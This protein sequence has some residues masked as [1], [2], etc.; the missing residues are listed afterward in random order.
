[1]QGLQSWLVMERR[2]DMYP[3]YGGLAQPLLL[4]WKELLQTSSPPAAS[5]YLFS[6]FALVS[7]YGARIPYLNEYNDR[8]RVDSHRILCTCA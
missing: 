7:K 4:G 1:M 3:G 8:T 6:F 5:A 2:V